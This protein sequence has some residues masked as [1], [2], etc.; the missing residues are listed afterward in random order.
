MI[1]EEAGAG[2]LGLLGLGTGLAASSPS[3][4][5]RHQRTLA[6]LVL[7][8]A[9]SERS[10]D[11][12]MSARRFGVATDRGRHRIELIQDGRGAFLFPA[13]QT[14]SLGQRGLHGAGP[15][16]LDPLAARELIDIRTRHH[17]VGRPDD[18]RLFL[19]VELAG[20]N[21]HRRVDLVL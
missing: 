16:R 13:A 21:Q 17:R 1:T 10:T 9:A 4:Q 18:A 3:P 15:L 12:I 6:A 11:R 7:S 19:R 8:T 2:G 14:I 20:S 5:P